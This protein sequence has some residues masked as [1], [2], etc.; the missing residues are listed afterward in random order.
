MHLCIFHDITITCQQV[1]GHT[2]TY[3]L[4]TFEANWINGSWD[5]STFVSSPCFFPIW[6][7]SDHQRHVLRTDSTT[8]DHPVCPGTADAITSALTARMVSISL[9]V[10][11]WDS[12]DAYHS[13][14]I[15]WHTLEEL[16]SPQPHPTRQWGPS[17]ICFCNPGNQILGLACTM[18]TIQQ[19]KGTESDQG[20]S[21][22]LPWPNP[23]GMT[24]DINT[25]V[26]LGE[27]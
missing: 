4:S 6:P 3:T 5:I 17:Q 18:D 13:F 27:L 26:H 2:L 23:T 11:D 14:P 22:C 24:H 25:H 20:K 1:V 16:A 15:F 10:Y 8:T 21:F 9:S 12:Q 7:L 19:Q